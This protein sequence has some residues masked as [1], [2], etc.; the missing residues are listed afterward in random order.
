[1]LLVGAFVPVPFFELAPGPTFNTIGEVDGKPL[2]DIS[3]TPTFPT[4]GNLDMTTV[5]ERGGPDNAVYLGRVL[6]G[7]ADP[8]VRI[9]PREAFYPDDV[10]DGEIS[11]ENVRQFSD[12][13]SDSTA[14]ALRYLKRPYLTL[15]VVASVIDGT[16]ADGKLEPGD[17][18]L[19]VDTTT[20]TTRADVT[21]AMSTVTPGQTVVVKVRREGKGELVESIVSTSNPKDPSKAFLGIG[22]GED[23]KAPFHLEFNLGGVG[24]PSAGMML[25]LG[26][27]D[28]L[29]PGQLNGGQ[30]V[31]GTGT[32]TPDGLVGPIGGIE[33]KMVGARRAGA[34]LFLAPSE[35]CADV[36]K[37]RVPAGLTVAKVSTLAE[38]VDAV[39]AYV[40]GK[41]VTPCS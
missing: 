23:Y 26:I 24:G 38:S 40:A 17:E 11:A 33:Q 25:S 9:V 3:G 35:N 18:I 14:A 16:P 28:K 6:V 34:T 5:N 7:W 22:V 10:S 30:H 36:L 29:T 1:M 21:T 41:P 2:I 19:K 37:A 4:S 27:V 32:I 13:E 39:T 15:V 31:A 8:N 20:I 12:S